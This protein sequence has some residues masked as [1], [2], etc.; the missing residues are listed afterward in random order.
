MK[1]KAVCLIITILCASVSLCAQGNNSGNPSGPAASQGSATIENQMIAYD[2]LRQIADQMA[3]RVAQNCKC[4]NVLFNDPNAQSQIITAKAFDV[5]A[6]AL[7]NAYKALGPKVEAL[8]TPSLSDIAAL[9]GAIKSSATYS[10]QNFQP[11][12]Q[13]M[14][15]LLSI[16]LNKKNIALRTSILPGDL[17]AG[18]KGVQDKL[19][20]I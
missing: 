14:I 19:N 20:E 18:A 13:S 17:D 12:P 8:A 16:A 10:N 3:E 4:T 1:T 5:S 7:I 9:L 6:Q 2:V 15:T 11:T